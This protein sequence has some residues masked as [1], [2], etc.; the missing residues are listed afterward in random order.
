MFRK[1]KVDIRVIIYAINNYLESK[2]PIFESILT[3]NREV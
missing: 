2:F 3:L 1:K